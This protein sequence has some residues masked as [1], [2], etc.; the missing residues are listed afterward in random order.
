MQRCI[1][2]EKGG[3]RPIRQSDLRNLITKIPSEVCNDTGN[4]PK[5]TSLRAEEINQQ[6]N[7]AG[8]A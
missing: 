4:E 8:K 5:L 6:K 1:S 2:Y 7:I 3:F